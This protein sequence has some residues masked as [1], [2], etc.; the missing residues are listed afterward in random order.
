MPQSVVAVFLNEGIKI[1]DSQ[2]V[3]S[4]LGLDCIIDLSR[5]YRRKLQATVAEHKENP[6]D[7]LKREIVSRR[8]K[9]QLRIIKWREDQ[10][11]LMPKVADNILGEAACD[12]E[13][14]RLFLPSCLDATARLEA[15]ATELGVE[16]GKLREG[17]AFDAL[18]ATQ[19]AVKALKTL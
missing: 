14:E 7:S 1:Q 3:F 2:C 8:T 19:T 18:R 6:L 9:L 10:K 17:A 13:D 12:V 5:K 4:L 11:L 16:E 15:D